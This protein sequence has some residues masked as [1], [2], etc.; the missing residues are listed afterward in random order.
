MKQMSENVELPSTPGQ[1][2]IIWV[3]IH[4]MDQA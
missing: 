2:D 4:K 1:C 3:G